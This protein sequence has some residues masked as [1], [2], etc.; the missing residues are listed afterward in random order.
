MSVE[1]GHW[2]GV[3]VASGIL[4]GLPTE[5][6]GLGFVARVGAAL[7]LGE[8]TRAAPGSRG[9]RLARRVPCK[10]PDL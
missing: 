9:C 1:S 3:N 7:A 2:Q 5:P 4:L 6:E 8:L 10:D